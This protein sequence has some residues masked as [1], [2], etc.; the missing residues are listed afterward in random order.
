[1]DEDATIVLRPPA[2]AVVA[3]SPP[4]PSPAGRRLEDALVRAGMAAAAGLLATAR[5]LGGEAGSPVALRDRLEALVARIDAALGEQIRL[6]LHEPSFQ[7]LEASWRGLHH[8]VRGAEGSDAV[9]IRV[10]SL[11]KRELARTLRKYRGAA[12]DQSPIFR[13]IYEEAYGQLGGEPFGVLIGDYSFDHQPEDVAVLADI[14][15]IAAAA[16]APFIAAAAPSVLQMESWAELAN[17]RDLSRIFRTAEYAAWRALR[18]GEDTR[19]LALCMPRFLARLPYGAASD[20]VD[21][22]AFEEQA[23]GETTQRFVWANA[24]FALGAN[25]LRAFAVYGWCARIRGVAS[26]GIVEDLPSLCFP[27][28]DGDTDR[29]CCTEI[30]L[31][32]RRE[33]E[34]ASNGFVPLVHLKNTE[35]AVFLSAQSL[36]KPRHYDDPDATAN[37][38]LAARLPYLFTSCRFAHY[39]KCMVRDKVG[40]SLSRSQVESWLLQWLRR[41]VDGSPQTSS[42]E[43]KAAHPLADA[44]VHLVDR[45]AAPGHYE[46]R[47]HLR[48]HYQLEGLTVALRLVSRLSSG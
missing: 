10:L 44:R 27:T 24:A 6:V 17:P 45:K 47:F 5:A 23:D 16:H 43:W 7:A 39:L 18:E 21:A 35:H 33:S 22:F 4:A 37:A 31:S 14:A 8:L 3:V 26:G 48:P 29:R 12:W 46:A 32:E 20:P 9:K 34:L 41:Y 38:V 36:Q 30:A 15:M 19:Y 25:I 13:R 40:S 42:E 11:S 1:M 2:P 28:A